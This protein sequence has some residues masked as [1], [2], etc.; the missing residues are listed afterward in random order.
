MFELFYELK[1]EGFVVSIVSFLT[2]ESSNK[3]FIK[4]HSDINSISYPRFES[5]DIQDVPV[6]QTI[7][8]LS[9]IHI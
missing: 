4:W 3:K 7:L 9:L 6:H 5:V 2:N 8:P 1:N